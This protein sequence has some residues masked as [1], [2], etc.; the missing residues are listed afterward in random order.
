MVASAVTQKCLP[1]PIKL[2][3]V[4]AATRQWYTTSLLPQVAGKIVGTVARFSCFVNDPFLGFAVD[5]RMIFPA[6]D[7]QWRKGEMRQYRRW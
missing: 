4:H 7:L 3:P 5:G 6:R 2:L 1:V